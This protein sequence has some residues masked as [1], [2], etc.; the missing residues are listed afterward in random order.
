MAVILN[1]HTPLIVL[2]IFVALG[3]LLSITLMGGILAMASR[4]SALPPDIEENWKN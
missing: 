3:S 2:V 4:T 1:P